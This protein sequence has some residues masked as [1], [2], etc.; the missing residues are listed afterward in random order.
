MTVLGQHTEDF[1]KTAEILYLP[2][3]KL[4]DHPLH[5]DFYLQSH[6]E[7]L[8]NS[9]KEAGLIEPIVVTPEGE[10]YTILS[11]HYR[12]RAVRRLKWKKVLC[13]VVKC[14]DRL[15]TIIYCTSNVLTR[16]F[17]AMEEAHMISGLVL[18]KH[19]TMTEIGKFW[20]RSK[21]WV[22]RRLS[23]VT[24][25]DPKIKKEMEK[26]FLPPRLAQ[27]LARLPR[28]NDQARVLKLIQ[29]EQLDKDAAAKLVSWWLTADEAKRQDLLSKGPDVLAKTVTKQLTDCRILLTRLISTVKGQ[30]VSPWW[31]LS[32]YH[33]LT[34]TFMELRDVL[35]E[36]G[37]SQE[38]RD[39]TQL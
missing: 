23:L 7:G 38:G 33:S 9:I 3:R 32:V 6:L 14:D 15:A 36:Q 34:K 11:G 10:D 26:G 2:C 17:S 21:S 24:R 5:F 1:K 13:R 27:E 30:E 37:F 19:F 16:G 12:I 18:E 20:G 39:E 25:L 8:V 31:P 4:L 28:G 35:R 29:S 22:S